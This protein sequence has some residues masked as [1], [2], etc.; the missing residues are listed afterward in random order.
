[1]VASTKATESETALPS[2]SPGASGG[3]H[4]DKD[5]PLVDP[6]STTVHVVLDAVSSQ[7]RGERS[8]AIDRMLRLAGVVGSTVEGLLFEIMGTA[9]HPKFREVSRLVRGRQDR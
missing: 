4:V 7:R 9:K 3:R 8:V 2:F 5:V 1:M 6:L